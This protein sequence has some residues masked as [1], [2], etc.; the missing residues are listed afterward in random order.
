ME[1]RSRP[2]RR[3]SRRQLEQGSP[4]GAGA[5]RISALH[6]DLLLLVLARL[7]CVRTAARTSVLSR[8]WRDNLWT[9]LP[10][11]VFRNI[12]V[13]SLE[14][15]LGHISRPPPVVS[16]LEIRI[17][18]P[19][20]Q[21]H[22]VHNARLNSLF[23]AVARLEPG[24]LVLDLPYSLVT[25]SL[26]LDLPCFRRATSIT[27]DFSSGVLRIPAGVEFPALEMLS[28][29]GIFTDVN[30]LL[31]R[32]PSLRTLQLTRVRF[33]GR[34]NHPRVTSASLQELTIINFPRYTVYGVHIV[35]PVLKQLTVSLTLWEATISVSA[36]MLEK[37]SDI[38]Y[39]SE[40]V[41]IAGETEKHMIIDC[42]VLELHLTTG[43]DVFGGLVFRLLGMDQVRSATRKLKVVLWR[44][45]VT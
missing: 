34:D 33:G 44:S 16:L 39:D 27:L 30:T 29:S 42:S 14:A 45:E 19:E 4:G 18:D 21:Q 22:K 38:T 23:C 10:A 17:P 31:S 1:S 32:C 28:L 6:D 7:G 40:G 20:Q 9:R 12:A 11:L 13:P 41:N 3:S 15:A 25:D 2:R 8:R 36:P 26:D 24:E 35:A 37:G 5:D 43:G